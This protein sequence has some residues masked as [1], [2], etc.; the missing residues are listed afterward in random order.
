MFDR[1]LNTYPSKLT[2]K[3]TN[4]SFSNQFKNQRQQINF[5]YEENKK[6]EPNELQNSWKKMLLNRINSYIF[7]SFVAQS[8]VS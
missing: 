3:V 7:D 1:F 5:C 2:S 4:V 8:N 6:K